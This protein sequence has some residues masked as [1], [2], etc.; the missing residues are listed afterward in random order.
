MSER[1]SIGE[2]KRPAMETKNANRNRN[3]NNKAILEARFNDHEQ[4][5]ELGDSWQAR[6]LFVPFCTGV[7]TKN[8][9]IEARI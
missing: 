3:R 4:R 2:Q 8:D 9:A 5:K 7:T 1:N 6:V